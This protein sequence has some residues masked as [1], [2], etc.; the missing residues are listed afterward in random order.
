MGIKNNSVKIAGRESEPHNK[1]QPN[2]NNENH[3]VAQVRF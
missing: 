2:E 3:N 1:I